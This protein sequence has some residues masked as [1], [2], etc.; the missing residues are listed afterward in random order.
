MFSQK[1]LW[2]RFS[3]LAKYPLNE[4]QRKECRSDEEDDEDFYINFFTVG[5]ITKDARLTGMII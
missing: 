3:G 1:N 5:P 4:H 2:E